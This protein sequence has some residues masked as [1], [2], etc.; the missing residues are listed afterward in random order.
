[1]PLPD[2]QTESDV[3]RLVAA[4][5]DGITAD[6]VIGPYFEG[7]DMAAHLPKL[8]AFWSSVVFQTG[9]YRGRPFEKHAALEGLRAEHFAR[10]LQ[11][12]RA[13]VDAR[14]AGPRADLMK[15]RA[16]QIATIFQIKLGVYA[17]AEDMS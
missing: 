11:R 12:F 13:T 2:I 17:P 7:V 3:R 5:Y 15:S 4:F 1:M 6:P 10:W 14:H 16:E 9:S 8:C